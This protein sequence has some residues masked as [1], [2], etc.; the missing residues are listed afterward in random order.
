MNLIISTPI[1]KELIAAS[2]VTSLLARATPQGFTLVAK[3]AGEERVLETQR[4]GVR[5]FKH[6]DALAA[7][8]S[9]LGVTHF[10]VE[11]LESG[12]TTDTHE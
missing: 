7:Y 2:A 3:I 4:G 11:L 10:Q 6:L 9:Q 1:L 5:Q 12:R 8:V